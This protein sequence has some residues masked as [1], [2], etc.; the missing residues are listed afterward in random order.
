MQHA[1][2]QSQNNWSKHISHHIDID[3]NFV[4]LP[5]VKCLVIQTRFANISPS[6]NPNI[7]PRCEAQTEMHKVRRSCMSQKKRAKA[8]HTEAVIWREVGDKLQSCRPKWF[9]ASAES[10]K[11]CPPSSTN[12]CSLSQTRPSSPESRR[13]RSWSQGKPQADTPLRTPSN[14]QP[15][16]LYAWIYW[17]SKGSQSKYSSAFLRFPRL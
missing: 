3:S 14:T 17:L 1:F 8:S 12:H 7:L 5:E 15:C 16:A 6:M 11:F 10:D 13:S 9:M 4:Y 2:A